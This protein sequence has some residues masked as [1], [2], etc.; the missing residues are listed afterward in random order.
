LAA[1]IDISSERTE[2]QSLKTIA[3]AAAR[4]TKAKRRSHPKQPR[5]PITLTWDKDLGNAIEATRSS[6]L[7][8]LYYSICSVRLEHN[9]PLLAVGVWAFVESLC[10]LAGKN[11]DTDFLSFYSNQRLGELGAGGKLASTIRAALTRIAHN[12]NA[13]KHHEIAAS[14]DGDQL[15]ND[16]A[17]ITPLLI[18]SVQTLILKKKL[19]VGG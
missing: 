11:P 1:N 12:G 18:R 5:K 9:V 2:P 6:K 19:A 15:H 13:T 4:S 8:S 3:A 7:E 17:V 10:A 14:F 16:L